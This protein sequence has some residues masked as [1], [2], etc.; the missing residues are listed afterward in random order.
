MKANSLDNNNLQKA[1]IKLLFNK[2][3][4]NNIKLFGIS[5]KGSAV[6]SK[7]MD[8]LGEYIRFNDKLRYINLEDC[9][10]SGKALQILYPYLI[11]N[12]V[13]KHFCLDSNLSINDESVSIIKKILLD[14][15]IEKI[16]LRRTKIDNSTQYELSVFMISVAHARAG[17]DEVAKCIIN[18]EFVDIDN[19]FDSFIYG[20]KILPEWVKQRLKDGKENGFGMIGW[21]DLSKK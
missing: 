1:A 19:E 11:G 17:N 3:R 8:E 18:E 13:L 12:R 15:S 20:S 9:G 5:L 14:S 2:L 21:L 6:G 4:E 10:V 16:D 7:C